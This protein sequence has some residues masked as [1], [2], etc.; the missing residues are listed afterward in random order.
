MRIVGGP[1]DAAVPA[2]VVR[3]PVAIALQVRVVVLVVVRHGVAQ[4]EAVMR[5]NE[6][7]ARGGLAPV[8]PEKIRGT[9]E[10]FCESAEHPAA[11]VPERTHGVAVAIVPLAP[12]R[13]KISEM[14]AAEA[15]VPGLGD[16]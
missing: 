7:D 15:H 13:R 2:V 12:S 8:S 3:V 6:V 16:E 1:L 9:R 11:S 4:R 14:V 5:R 10:S